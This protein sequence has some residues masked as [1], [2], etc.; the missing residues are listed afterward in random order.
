[1][2]F[3]KSVIENIARHAAETPDKLCLADQ[4]KALT[5]KQVWDASTGLAIELSGRGVSRDDYVVIESNQS[6]D[7]MIVIFAVHLLKAIA[8]PLEQNAAASRMKEILAE[9]GSSLFISTRALDDMEHVS[10]FDITDACSYACESDSRKDGK[11]MASIDVDMIEFPDSDCVAEV[12]FSTGTTGK[13]KGVVLTHRNDIAIA[14]NVCTGVEQK[15]DNVELIPMP[16]SHSHGL[17][18]TYAN[19]CNGSSVVLIDGVMYLKKV[20]SLIEEYKVCSMDLSPSM[21]SIIFK[22]GGDRLGDYAEQMDYI[23][24]GSAP[25]A[26]EDKQ[27][28]ARILPHTRLYNFYGSTE[29]GCACLLDFNKMSGKP[30]CIG[31]PAVNAKFMVVDEDRNIIESSPNHLGFLACSGDITMREY[32]NAPELTAKA[33][34]DGVIYSRD[35]G[36]IDEDGLVYMLGRDDD[37]INF[38]GIKISPEEVEAVVVKHP[39]IEDCA[40]IPIDDPLTGQAPKLFIQLQSDAESGSGSEYDP[41]EFRSWLAANIDANKQPAKIEIIDRIPRTFNGKVKRQNLK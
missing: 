28:L 24:L 17:R 8:V 29:A 37:V 15:A 20:F 5:Y 34:K 23:Q 16:V 2:N 3:Y 6:V 13:S 26:E 30:G 7:Y 10:Y 32:F 22:L 41:K 18:R 11:Y 12:L 4:K 1:M 39:A 40:L 14:E 36:Y 25:L 38:G 9:T 31:K 21:L 33:M 27:H 19:M 35:L